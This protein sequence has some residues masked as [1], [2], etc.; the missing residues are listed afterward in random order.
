MLLFLPPR[1][2]AK[3]ESLSTRMGLPFA[4]VN[5]TEFSEFVLVT[6]YRPYNLGSTLVDGYLNILLRLLD[7][8]RLLSILPRLGS[9]SEHPN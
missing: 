7:I 6:P 8:I 4:A 5:F 3:F 9:L 2:N 1:S